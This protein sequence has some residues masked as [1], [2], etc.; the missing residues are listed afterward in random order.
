MH[1]N[2]FLHFTGAF[3][4]GCYVNEEKRISECEDSRC[5]EQIISSVVESNSSYDVYG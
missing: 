1:Y 5:L 3:G 4:K 2:I